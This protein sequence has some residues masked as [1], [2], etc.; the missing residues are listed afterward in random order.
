MEVVLTVSFLCRLFLRLTFRCVSAISATFV[1][2]VIHS[3]GG[4]TVEIYSLVIF[5]P[6]IA[7]LHSV[8]FEFD[9]HRCLMS[10]YLFIRKFV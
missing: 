10:L 4:V 5:E 6:G 8:F 3:L 1:P 9:V 7:L 2:T